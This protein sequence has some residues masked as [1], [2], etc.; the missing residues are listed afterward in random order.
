MIT[1]P[2][3]SPAQPHSDWLREC[4]FQSRHD[5]VIHGV[6]P[7]IHVANAAQAKRR[8]AEGWQFIAIT[9]ELKMMLDGAS[10]VLRGLG[11]NRLRSDLA[12]Y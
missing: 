7:G 3:H 4:G 5:P 12:K 8:I 6:A 11:G 10:A 1:P 2:T 9:S